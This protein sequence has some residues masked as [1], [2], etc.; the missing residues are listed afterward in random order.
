MKKVLF[1]VLLCLCGCQNSDAQHQA[2]FAESE[3]E[4]L[5]KCISLHKVGTMVKYARCFTSSFVQ[6]YSNRGFS[7]NNSEK[8]HLSKMLVLAEQVDKRKMSVYESQQILNEYDNGLAQ[9]AQQEQMQRSQQALSAWRAMQQNQQQ[10]QP[11]MMPTNRG[12]HCTSSPIGNTL[13]TDCD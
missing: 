2:A 8:L 10:Q 6:N 7:V 4:S 1:V 3:N 13:Y 5:A 11:Y 12:V 9:Q